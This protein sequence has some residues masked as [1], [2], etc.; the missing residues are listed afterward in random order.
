MQP[1]PTPD[2]RTAPPR[3]RIADL[4]VD[5]GKAEVTRGGEK[6]AL[7]K[8]SFDLLCAL[9]NAAPAIVTNDDLLAQ[10][11]PG[12]MVSPESVAQRVKL[13]RSAIGDDSQQPRYILGVRGRGYRLIPTVERLSGSTLPTSEAST[14]MPGAM[15]GGAAP[16]TIGDKG[17]NRRRIVIGAAVVIGLSAAIALGFHL[18][19]AKRGGVQAQRVVDTASKATADLAA[20]FNPPPHSIAVLP[21]VNISG[22]KEQQ[23]FS[24]GLTEELLN[25]LSRI[26]ELQVAARTSSFSFQGEHPDIFTV[27]HKLNVA[28]VLEGS[29][30]RSAH[31]VRVTTQL[32][33]GVTG[34]HIWSQT[35]DRNLSDVLA[36]Q[37]EIA[38]A[39]A[40]A[41]QVAL[42]DDL[43]AKI[44]LGGTRDPAAFDAY[45]RGLKA[46]VNNHD[47]KDV[48]T[49]I[50]AY[51]EA[52]Q[53]DPHFA[54]AFV[55]RSVALNV[56]GGIY[57]T[58]YEIGRQALD[59]ARA[60]AIKATELAPE[61]AGA[62][63]RLADAYT[64]KL[65]LTRASQEY[66]RALALAPGSAGVLLDYGLFAVYMG[67]TDPG[68]AAARRGVLL[69]RLN[70]NSYG[71]LGQALLYARH[72]EEAVAAFGEASLLDPNYY[73]PYRWDAYYELG[74]YQDARELCEAKPDDW[75]SH[76]C[77]AI[78]Y[79]KLGRHGDAERE[80]AK[81]KALNPYH[82]DWWQY[83]EIY[84]QWG[85]IPK[86]LD[87]LD[88]AMRMHHVAL[89][90]LK[91]DPLLDT[92]RKEP[93]FQA[94]ERALKFPD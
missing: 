50:D 68:V 94:I 60:D 79:D 70:R 5:I 44:E 41:L 15:P 3:F 73:H 63:L 61:L 25:S 67:R 64:L 81:L 1:A 20:G 17:S 30:R 36:L 2:N 14:T 80:L 37:T 22:D 29:V 78:T 83:A 77:L 38:N 53:L 51:S 31:T 12:L 88:E 8:L 92:L 90:G 45:L 86:A 21:F 76:L 57:E 16:E 4:E 58:D 6:I 26:N 39:V 84:A 74:K 7:P 35:Y 87:A 66:E 59:R 18:W 72:Y 85:A 10:V 34:F 89:F 24:D 33:S 75:S 9:I 55:G 42:I 91:V 48:Q 13:L 47:A 11:W 62:H 23:Y 46:F 40:S 69:D 52:I 28:A 43:A 19:T 82:N 56:L 27:A 71:L 54:R 65:D 93:R 32:V 49:A